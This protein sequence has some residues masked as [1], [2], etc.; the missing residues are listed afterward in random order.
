[1]IGEKRRYVSVNEIRKEFEKEEME[2]EKSGRK[3]NNESV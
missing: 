3:V 1:V 2:M